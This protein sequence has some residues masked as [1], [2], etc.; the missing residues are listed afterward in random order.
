VLFF[1]LLIAQVDFFYSEDTQ[2]ESQ[3]P[4]I[5]VPTHWAKTAQPHRNERLKWVKIL[6]KRSSRMK[7][8]VIRWNL[9]STQVER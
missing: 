9:Y 8:G 6:A 4:L 1:V 5:T 3:T 2:T 7:V